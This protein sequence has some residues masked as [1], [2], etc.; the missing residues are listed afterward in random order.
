M[1]IWIKLAAAAAVLAGLYLGW[2]SVRASIWDEG[3]AAHK[4]EVDR[5]TAIANE[6]ARELERMNRQSKENA[7][8]ARTRELV[9]NNRAADRIRVSQQ[10]LLDTSERSLQT[11]RADHAACVV[12]AATHAEL[13]ADC[14]ARY[15]QMGQAAQGH[16]TDIKT[17]IEAWPK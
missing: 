14:R 6:G 3:Y 16:L 2:Q 12:S 9:A 8:E 11:A 13:F 7:L 10:R 17:L 5:L 15:G 1:N 4:A